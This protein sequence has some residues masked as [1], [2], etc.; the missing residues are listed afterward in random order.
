MHAGQAAGQNNVYAPFTLERMRELGY[1]YFAL[2]HIH[3]RQTLLAKPLVVYPGNIQGRDIGELGA[4]G[5]YLVEVDE[6]S[7]QSQLTFCPTSQIVWEQANLVLDA[8]LSASDLAD[9]IAATLRAHESA[10]VKTLSV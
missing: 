3:A 8:P 2:G 6:E 5:C 7:G 4:K 1:D 9:K 10:G